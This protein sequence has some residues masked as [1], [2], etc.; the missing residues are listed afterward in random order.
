MIKYII[1]G[2]KIKEIY[3]KFLKGLQN[4]KELFKQFY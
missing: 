4:V 3:K 1:K 2:S